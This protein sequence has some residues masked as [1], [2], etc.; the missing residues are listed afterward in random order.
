MRKKITSGPNSAS[1]ER[2]SHWLVLPN[3]QY[4]GGK[5]VKM[6]VDDKPS[7]CYWPQ[8]PR[9]VIGKR[10]ARCFII[11]AWPSLPDYFFPVKAQKESQK[12]NPF[13]WQA[14][15]RD[16]L[17]SPRGSCSP[18]P[19]PPLSPRTLSPSPTTF[20]PR[21]T[22]TSRT[23]H[24]LLATSRPVCSSVQLG[25][26]KAFH[27]APQCLANILKKK[28]HEIVLFLRSKLAQILQKTNKQKPEKT[29]HK[30][31]STVMLKYTHTH[32]IPTINAAVFSE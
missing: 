1:L 5:N 31:I 28:K 14:W 24:L 20:L 29:L 6:K 18:G 3:V 2:R 30:S 25:A 16:D 8:T 7:R 26:T 9:K 13:L 32:H 12:W 21:I 17:P 22:D 4:G 23:R 27:R 10:W 19:S 11:G 15:L